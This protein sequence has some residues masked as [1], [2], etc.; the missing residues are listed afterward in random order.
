MRTVVE[1]IKIFFFIKFT[2]KSCQEYIEKLTEYVTV[3]IGIA[4][5]GKPVAGVIY[6]P[7]QNKTVWGLNLAGGVQTIGTKPS[8]N[9]SSWKYHGESFEVQYLQIKRQ[10]MTQITF[11]FLN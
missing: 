1:N 9:V 11:K 5:K 6:K 4:V 7:F 8:R 3:M 2:L 10:K